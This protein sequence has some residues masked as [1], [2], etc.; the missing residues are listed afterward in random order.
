MR[1]AAQTISYEVCL[2]FISFF[3]FVFLGVYDLYEYLNTGLMRLWLVVL[4][5]LWLIVIFAE[6]N[7]AP[8]DFSEGE[9]ELV[10]GF[11]TEYG[12][13]EFAF[14]FLGEYGQIIFLSFV[15]ILL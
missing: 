9:R 10:S 14:L 12:A 1:G 7:R 13:M 3:P 4:V 6:T 2:V 15:T 5:C 11:N 8:L